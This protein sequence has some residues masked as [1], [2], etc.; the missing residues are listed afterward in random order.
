MAEQIAEQARA[1][2][3][4]S[5]GRF[6]D[7]TGHRRSAATLRGARWAGAGP[8][9]DARARGQQPRSL[10]I[11]QRDHAGDRNRDRRPG[12]RA[13]AD[14]RTGA[15]DAPPARRARGRDQGTRRRRAR[16]AGAPAGPRELRDLGDAFNAMGEDLSSAQSRIEEERRR[17]AVTIESLGDA[18]LVTEPGTSKIATTNPARRRSRPRAATGRPNRWPAEPA[19][20]APGGA[21]EGDGDRARRPHPGGH[22]S[23]ARRGGRR[24]R[25]DGARRDRTRPPRAGQER[26]RGHRVARAAQPADLDQGIRRA[27]RAQPGEHVRAPARVHRH[28]AAVDRPARGAGQRSAR[29]GPDRGRQRRDRRAGRSTSAR[30]CAT[31]SS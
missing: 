20:A 15:L 2:Q 7:R 6:A 17:L 23:A 8:S 9:A 11:E 3:L 16:A 26:V 18:L 1:R 21:R 30:R 27:A 29:R 28:R 31:S 14:R 13:G 10:A 4:A 5:I 22:R 19:A 24:R 12:R 25:L